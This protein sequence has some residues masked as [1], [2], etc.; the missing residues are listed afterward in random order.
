MVISVT[1]NHP[2]TLPRLV[3]LGRET[4]R[5]AREYKI[6]GRELIPGAVGKEFPIR[7]ESGKEGNTHTPI[8][9]YP[10]TDL[11]WAKQS[12][13]ERAIGKTKKLQPRGP[14]KAG[15]R[16]KRLTREKPRDWQRAF[17]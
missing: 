11:H 12:Q 4:R 3:A 8:R 5:K 1:G 7:K 14:S 2:G 13:E 6:R 9:F 15:R 16:E 10:G 17:F